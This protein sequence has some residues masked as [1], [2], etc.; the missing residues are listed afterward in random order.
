MPNRIEMPEE[1]VIHPE[2]YKIVYDEIKNT[3]LERFEDEQHFESACEDGDLGEFEFDNH[4]LLDDIEVSAKQMYN[5]ISYCL[6]NE[7]EETTSI[8]IKHSMKALIERYAWFISMSILEDDYFLEDVKCEFRYQELKEEKII[9]YTKSV[10]THVIPQWRI[11]S[12]EHQYSMDDVI[13]KHAREQYNKLTKLRHIYVCAKSIE[14]A[15]YMIEDMRKLIVDIFQDT[16]L[17]K[18]HKGELDENLW[19]KVYMYKKKR[20][21]KLESVIEEYMIYEHL[22]EQVI[23]FRKSS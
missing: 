9:I 1:E 2:I 7:E 6:R 10:F 13:K 4:Y 17:E 23:Q 11:A 15:K 3:L 20:I 22:K 21:E 14:I 18:V 5:M 8:I 12:L 16:L 19:I